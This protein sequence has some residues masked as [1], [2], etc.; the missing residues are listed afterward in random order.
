MLAL[1]RDMTTRHP[2]EPMWTIYD[3]TSWKKN[4]GCGN[5]IF[6]RKWKFVLNWINTETRNETRNE[7]QIL[8]LKN[9]IHDHRQKCSSLYSAVLR[10]KTITSRPKKTHGRPKTVVWPLTQET[11]VPRSEEGEGELH[12]IG[13]TRLN[14]YLLSF[15]SSLFSWISFSLLSTV[16]QYTVDVSEVLAVPILKKNVHQMALSNVYGRVLW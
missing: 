10:H 3:V 11:S 8:S 1:C 4:T 6:H 5:E 12:F 15:A 14:A 16:Q 7:L 2:A 9:W 13:R